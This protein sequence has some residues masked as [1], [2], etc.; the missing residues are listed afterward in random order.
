[1]TPEQL[2]NLL[3]SS[4]IDENVTLYRQLFARTDLEK[5]SDPYWNRALALFG[6]LC[7]EQREFFFEVVRQV[8]IDTTSSVLGVI[9]GASRPEGADG[10]FE[11]THNGDLQ[12][13]FL[14][15]EERRA[16][17]RTVEVR[18]DIQAC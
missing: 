15:E 2:V 17:K 16:K 10:R 13:L 5:A 12:S 4:V 18:P 11:L 8:A 3:H 14:V 9:D 6:G 7:E 1:M